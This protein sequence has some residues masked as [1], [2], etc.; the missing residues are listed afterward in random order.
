MAA[1]SCRFETCIPCYVAWSATHTGHCRSFV[2]SKK[3]FQAFSLSV[4]N[5]IY[6]CYP[7]VHVFL[8]RSSHKR[9]NVGRQLPHRAVLA[10]IIDPWAPIEQPV[11]LLV[12]VVDHAS[13]RSIDRRIGMFCMPVSAQLIG[14]PMHHNPTLPQVCS[15]VFIGT[16][17]F[18][19]SFLEDAVLFSSVVGTDAPDCV[20][21][22]GQLEVAVSWC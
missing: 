11:A 12:L 21:D 19:A 17:N 3:N 20:F 18:V 9:P 8:Q 15:Q 22:L 1:V 4:H 6:G 10:G 2:R 7:A 5:F 14:G 16:S 13:R